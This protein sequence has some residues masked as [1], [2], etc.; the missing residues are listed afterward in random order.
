MRLRSHLVVLVL[1]LLVPMAVFATITIVAFGLQQRAAV[2]QG[3]VETARALMNAVDHN[4]ASS[5]ATIAALSTLRSLDRPDL[6]EFYADA[7]RAL[8]SQPQWL[9][10]VLFEPDGQQVLNLLRPLGS[11]LPAVAERRSFDLVLTTRVPAVGDIVKGPVSDEYV[12]AVRTPVLRSGAVV[13]VLTAVVKPAAVVEV[14]TRQRMPPDSVATIFDQSK[15]IVAR[16][17]NIDQFLGRSV[18]GEFAALLDAE[19]TE[20]WAVTRTLEGV[21]VHTAFSRSRVSGWGVGLGIP[22]ASVEA[23]LQ[24]GLI[25][26]I[27]GGLGFIALALLLAVLVSRR[28]TRPILAL[29]SAAKAFGE[30]G[31]MPVRPPTGVTEI[32]NMSQVF[33]EAAALV[34]RRAEEAARADVAARRLAALVESSDDAIIGKTLDGIITFWNPAA[35]RMYGY[36]EAEAVGQSITLIVPADRLDEEVEV[37]RRLRLGETL[38][39]FETVRVRKDGRRLD[40]SL[41]VS[42]IRDATGRIVGASKIARDI[43]EQKRAQ[44]ERDMLLERE[45]AARLEA[46]AANRA[47][48]E[49]LA[50]LSHELRTPLNAVYGWAQMLR[51]ESMSEEQKARAL[52]TI[53]RNAN[54]QLQLI[55]DL[56]DVSRVVSGKMRLN[57]R[58]V[59]LRT[60]VEAA[61]D[62]VRPAA[63]AKD[64]RL[65]S[66]LDPRAGPIT[67]DP[68][69]LQQV[70]WNL[71]MNAVKFTPKGGRVQVH[72]QRVNSHIEVVV[73]DTG[74]GIPPAVLPF[75]FDRFRQADSSSTRAHS[76][77]GL[78]LALVKHLVELHGGSVG[79]QSPGPGQGATFIVKLPLTIAEVAAGP[80]RRIHPTASSIDSIPAVGRLDGLRVLV[81]DDD[82]DALD[83][84][85]MILTRAGAEVRLCRSAAEAIDMLGRWRPDVLVSDIEMPIED[86]YA[87]IRK[88]RALSAEHGGRTPAVALTAYGRMQDRVQSLTAGYNMHVA[89]PVDPGEFT[90]IIASL[91]GRM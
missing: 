60:V 12:F 27:V 44:A 65:Q 48:D 54:A 78:G 80:E 36:T 62:S 53:A 91:A 70:V 25:T 57:V 45:Q 46:E 74:E 56:L 31:E 49:F 34:R 69:R 75:V 71:L 24:R 72:L 19:G 3:T 11:K 2:Q 81:V 4:L 35:V 88:V 17:K 51:G 79:A 47:K 61:I 87:L 86:G 7:Q 85:S 73:S 43:T 6:R 83:L 13:Y 90:A 82:R 67:G 26:T 89:K 64:I 59:D 68:D 21:P 37:L 63:A 32:E 50:V 16:T 42:P 29:S 30:G 77:L 28:M 41:T 38:D 84:S 20:G 66:V 22:R 9:T 14:L 23:P 39:H 55:D 1:A 33:A 18:S 15:R 58:P 10:I 5:I 76:G 8:A 40:I 52:E